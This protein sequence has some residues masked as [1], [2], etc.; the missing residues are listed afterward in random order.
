MCFEITRRN[1]FRRGS[2]FGKIF[3]GVLSGLSFLTAPFTFGATI[4]NGIALA[5]VGAAL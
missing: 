4:P 3:F 1:R 2:L 5:S